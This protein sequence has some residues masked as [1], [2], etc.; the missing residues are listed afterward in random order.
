MCSQRCKNKPQPE[1]VFG[2]DKWPYSQFTEGAKK[3]WRLWEFGVLQGARPPFY[4]GFWSWP[5]DFTQA[6]EVFQK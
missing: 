2:T 4:T 6:F 1:N 5:V 3:L